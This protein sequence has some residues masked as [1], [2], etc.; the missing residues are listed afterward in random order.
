MII[1]R[2]WKEG[3]SDEADIQQEGLAEAKERIQN[4]LLPRPTF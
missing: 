4:G 3:V 1:G 2:I